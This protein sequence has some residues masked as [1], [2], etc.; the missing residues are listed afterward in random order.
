MTN[1]RLAS[2]M[3]RGTAVLGCRTAILC[4]AMSWVS[5]RHLVSAISN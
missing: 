3:A 1:A 4:G 2:L 5:E